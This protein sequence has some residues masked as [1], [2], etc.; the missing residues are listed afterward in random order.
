[1]TIL[2]FDSRGTGDHAGRRRNRFFHSRGIGDSFPGNIE[3][4]PVVDRNTKKRQTGRYGNGTMKIE[5]L[6][7]NMPLVMIEGNDGII[8]SL[9]RLCKNGIGTDRS[10]SIDTAGDSRCDSR[11]DRYHLF[12]SQQSVFSAMRIESG[13]GD[14]GCFD[15]PLPQNIPAT[16]NKAA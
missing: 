13:Y 5:R 15:S 9:C 7:G 11:S 12:V 1:M 4:R 10:D 16:Q 8:S 14:T 3:S 6:A 2:F